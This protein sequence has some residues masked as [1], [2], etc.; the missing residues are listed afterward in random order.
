[1]FMDKRVG[2]VVAV[3]GLVLMALGF[4]T[5]KIDTG[6]LGALP[7]LWIVGGGVVLIV[8]GVAISLMDKGG[9]GKIKHAKEEVPI[10]EGVGKN[11]K[12]VGYRK[13]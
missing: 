2:Y 1:M 6:F 9:G 13:D 8:V 4:G 11:R 7:E 10:Y 3:V 5:F 12:I